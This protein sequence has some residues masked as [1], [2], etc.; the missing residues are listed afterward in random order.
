MSRFLPGCNWFSKI[1]SLSIF[2]THCCLIFKM[3][4]IL[5]HIERVCPLTTRFCTVCQIL[6]KSVKALVAIT[7]THTQIN[8]FFIPDCSLC[9]LIH[10]EPH[11]WQASHSSWVPT[12]WYRTPFSTLFTTSCKY[13]GDCYQPY[14]VGVSTN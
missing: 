12:Q 11:L 1:L 9:L 10:L 8:I 7:V 13:L 6:L 2:K 4:G 14:V 5:K 3:A